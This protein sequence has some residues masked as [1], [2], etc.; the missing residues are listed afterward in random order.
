MN[1][2]YSSHS[3]LWPSQSGFFS[4]GENR[5]RC[6]PDLCFLE[7]KASRM[8]L[9]LFPH[10]IPIILLFYVKDPYRKPIFS[11]FGGMFAP[12]PIPAINANGTDASSFWVR[13]VGSQAKQ[14]QKHRQAIH[15][16]KTSHNVTDYNRPNGDEDGELLGKGAWA[17]QGA[18]RASYSPRTGEWGA[19]DDPSTGSAC[20]SPVPPHR[21]RAWQS[22][23]LVKGS[24]DSPKHCK[25]QNRSKVQPESTN[26]SKR[27]QSQ[28]QATTRVQSPS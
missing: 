20:T 2:N 19:K 10:A 8:L 13:A 23:P 18:A 27:R 3:P 15:S 14:K 1:H 24:T 12:L 22:W 6:F 28:R 25:W 11:F 26:R 7:M 21:G 5:L 17:H 9:L 16:L 4:S